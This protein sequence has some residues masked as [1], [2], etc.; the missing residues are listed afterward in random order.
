MS[1]IERYRGRPGRVGRATWF[2][3]LAVT[4]LLAAS[5]PAG[6]RAQA[7]EKCD[8]EY[9]RA[10][11]EYLE[12]RF[13]DAINALQSCLDREQLFRDEAVRVY[14]LMALAYL[15]KGD[16][17]QARFAVVNLLSRDAAYEPDA[18]QDPPTY[19]SLVNL[20]Q[21]QLAVNAPSPAE[22][23]PAE[24]V[25]ERPRRSW[26]TGPRQWLLVA[27]GAVV[28]GTAAALIF[29]GS[30]SPGGNTSPLPLPPAFP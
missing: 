1:V 3:C 22:P 5:A 26:L 27:G 10:E 25:D 11:A 21:E 12:G 6:V 9:E 30:D 4:L 24:G 7:R 28:V 13:D 19:V 29:S 18:V 16:V 14:R 15:N 17:E 8:V 2:V 20:V 23:E